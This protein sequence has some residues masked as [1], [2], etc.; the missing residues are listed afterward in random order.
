[1]NTAVVILNWNGIEHLQT[2]LPS[3]VKH[4]NARIYIIDNGSSDNSVIWIRETYAEIGIIQLERNL[5]FAGGY[6]NGLKKIDADRYVLLNSDVRVSS[7]WI[8]SV[9]NTMSQNGWS[10]C[11]PLILDD[12]NPEYYEYAGAAG[13][14]IDKDG[15]MFCAGR[16]FD[17]FEK[18]NQTYNTDREVFW[19]SG[20][21]LFID[22]KAWDEVDGL[23]ADFFAHMEEIDL[24]WRLKT[25]GHKVGICGSATVRHLGGGTL[26][27]SNP[28]KVY[29]NFRNNLLILLKNETGIPVLFISKRLILDGIA[30]FRFLLRGELMFFFSIVKAHFVF[31]SMILKTLSKRR[32]E[33]VARNNS[34]PNNIGRYKRSILVQYFIKNHTKLSD[35]SPSDFE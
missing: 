25:R 15:Y 24:C 11:S 13:G 9:N 33:S 30:A 32:I 23:D 21:A 31:Y 7:G 12:K 19:A 18:V 14:L 4:S 20:A 34:T 22:S 2:Y 27:A 16:L 35:L 26:T 28:L 8:E 1:M 10:V 29:L 6:N 3:V 5:G 17:S